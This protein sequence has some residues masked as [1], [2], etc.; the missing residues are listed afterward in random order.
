M[1]VV[2]HQPGQTSVTLWVQ[3]EQSETDWTI[4]VV[5]PGA[6][7]GPIR[8]D[9]SAP[10]LLTNVLPG[11]CDTRIWTYPVKELLP[12]STYT[13]WVSAPF[14]PAPTVAATFRT[15][16]SELRDPFTVLLASCYSEDS[17]LAILVGQGL[18]GEVFRT[19]V[20]T[21][22][23]GY[24]TTRSAVQR[25]IVGAAPRGN[26]SRRYKLLCDADGEPDLKILTGDQV[27]LDTPLVLPM[28]AGAIRRRISRTYSRTWD[29]LGFLLSHGANICASG[30][31]E[32]WNNYPYR[33]PFITN[34]LGLR[35][36]R[37]RDEWERTARDFVRYVQLAQPVVTFELGEDLSFFVADT[38]INRDRPTAGEPASAP[39]FM[40]DEDFDQLIG[41]IAGLKSPGV[42]VVGQPLLSKGNPRDR[43]L[44]DFPSSTP[45]CA[46]RWCPRRGMWSYSVGTCTSA[47]WPRSTSSGR[48]GAA[49]PG[50]SR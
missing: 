13:V 28:F 33:P 17:D 11:Q 45:G 3:A 30:D 9:S 27:Y 21:L 44:P 24:V 31:H 23:R 10:D 38:R 20:Q 47:G 34:L 19:L 49:V 42:L 25:E 37:S 8:D 26:V 36:Q 41:W 39:K 14:I 4:E 29:K 40:L 32:F 46:R 18:L 22:R 5:G 50:S 35:G 12:G 15:L 1:H 48:T 6:A 43:G 16:P 7:M 2:A